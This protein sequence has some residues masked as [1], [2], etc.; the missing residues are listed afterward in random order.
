MQHQCHTPGHDETVLVA[1]EVRTGSEYGAEAQAEAI[2][3]GKCAEAAGAVAAAAA[4]W[5]AAAAAVEVVAV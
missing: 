4:L 3:A 5:A 1:A 2:A